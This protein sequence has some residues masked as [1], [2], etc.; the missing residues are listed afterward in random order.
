M[1]KLLLEHG[2]DPIE[3]DAEPWATPVAWAKKTGRHDVAALLE[4]A[5]ARR[6]P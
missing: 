4:K 3:A 2:A 5:A 1:V 6:I